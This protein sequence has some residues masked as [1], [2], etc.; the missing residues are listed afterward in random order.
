MLCAY[1]MANTVKLSSVR[2]TIWDWLSQPLGP[3]L[4]NGS[5]VIRKSKIVEKKAVLPLIQLMWDKCTAQKKDLESWPPSVQKVVC[6]IPATEKSV[7]DF[8]LKFW[9][10]LGKGL[11]HDHRASELASLLRMVKPEPGPRSCTLFATVRLLCVLT[12]PSTHEPP[13]PTLRGSDQWKSLSLL[14][15]Q[16]LYRC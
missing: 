15:S 2:N 14:L 6:V 13:F 9:S 11:C 5:L 1:F 10:K 3:H 4:L 16:N 12:S 8:S 7:N